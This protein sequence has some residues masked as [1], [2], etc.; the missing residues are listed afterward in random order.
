MKF[1]DLSLSVSSKKSVLVAATPPP[2]LPRGHLLPPTKSR[3]L[4]R[5]G[6][7]SVSKVKVNH[8]SRPI[9]QSD[10]ISLSV[11]SITARPCIELSCRR[12]PTCSKTAW[13]KME[14]YQAE[15]MMTPQPQ[16]ESAAGAAGSAPMHLSSNSRK[17]RNRKGKRPA[18][19]RP[20]VNVKS[21]LF[22][23]GPSANTSTRSFGRS[24]GGVRRPRSALLPNVLRSSGK[25]SF[26]GEREE[27]RELKE[28]IR[29][30]ENAG[31]YRLA[32]SLN[33]KLTSMLSDAKNEE[34][35]LWIARHK[36]SLSHLDSKEIES[37][38]ELL[39][40]WS[41]RISR[42][43]EGAIDKLAAIEV[44]CERRAVCWTAGATLLGP[45]KR[46]II[47]KPIPTQEKHRIQRTNV[48]EGKTSS[49]DVDAAG[50]PK[51]VKFS[52][53]VLDLLE[54]E[55]FLVKTKRYEEAARMRI[56]VDSVA[57]EEMLSRMENSQ[58][59]TKLAITRLK[60]TQKLE[61]DA[62][63]EKT[64]REMKKLQMTKAQSL[65]QLAMKFKS[66]R[67]ACGHA[68]A[69]QTNRVECPS[70]MAGAAANAASQRGEIAA[71]AA[72]TFAFEP[73]DMSA[74]VKSL[75]G[76]AASPAGGLSPIRTGTAMRRRRKGKATK[77]KRKKKKAGEGGA[78]DWCASACAPET[79]VSIPREGSDTG[80]GTFCRWECA[81]AY[82]R[83]YSPVQKRYL[84]E[85][86]LCDLSGRP[87]LQA[88]PA[89]LHSNRPKT[90]ERPFH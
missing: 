23:I 89:H 48:S 49:G 35:M 70:P 18:S 37:R 15:T 28:K 27:L 5:R 55:K 84:E 41:Q 60:R 87:N 73:L 80:Y 82:S 36:A 78:C 29:E 51:R 39:R 10:G 16:A 30:S 75:P 26:Q 47:I 62:F 71:T 52:S 58:E 81:L 65:K 14:D 50:S 64:T 66:A 83:A 38:K 2:S 67:E 22:S 59:N 25:N 63:T 24:G 79:S 12:Q 17:K 13:V 44:G 3:S 45:I 11:S 56:L 21:Q 34:A 1:S 43:K 9:F 69:L 7:V 8:E 77:K 76:L 57:K 32:H 90:R 68:L 20:K 46:L 54:R 31:D 6:Y 86:F 61:R 33:Q 85:L 74:S 40:K 88:A 42:Y 53:H 72:S 4:S 19:A